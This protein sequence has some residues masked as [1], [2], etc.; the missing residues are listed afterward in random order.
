MPMLNRET[1]ILWPNETI[2]AG[3]DV[4]IRDKDFVWSIAAHVTAAWSDRWFD[5]ID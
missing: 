5:V 4:Q 1:P 2:S 3:I